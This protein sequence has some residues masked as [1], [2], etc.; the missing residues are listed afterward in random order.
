[1]DKDRFFAWALCGKYNYSL[2]VSSIWCP[3][4]QCVH[5]AKNQGEQYSIKPGSMN[6]PTQ[7]FQD[8]LKGNITLR[9]LLVVIVSFVAI[10]L[11]AAALSGVVEDLTV[12]G[13]AWLWAQLQKPMLRVW[14]LL[15]ALV[16]M[17]A[18]FLLG[19]AFARKFSRISS[20]STR[21]STRTKLVTEGYMVQ[22][23]SISQGEIFAKLH[24]LREGKIGLNDYQIFILEG[25]NSR[26]ISLSEAKHF[27]DEVGLGV[28][29]NSN[30][31]YI[32]FP[33]RQV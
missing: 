31:T 10:W 14:A 21:S 2:S 6:D 19:I 3:R 8:Y 30:G 29:R 11:I 24:E 28:N 16:L 25:L 20:S 5:L 4:C 12:K 18:S 7:S 9:R 32:V 23:N 22:S 27:L 17:S 15:L 26:K 1:M 33:K 13:A